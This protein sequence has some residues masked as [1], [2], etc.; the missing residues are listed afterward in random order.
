VFEQDLFT[1]IQVI[2]VG[3]VMLDQYWHGDTSRISPEA[4]VPVLKVESKEYRAGG[5]ANV[6]L[7]AAKLG[8][9][10]SIL[11]VVG[12]DVAARKLKDLLVVD[13]VLCN[14]IVA[15]EYPTTTKL[16]VVARNQQLIRCDTES[17]PCDVENE[18]IKAFKIIVQNADVVILSD[19]AKGVLS[20][21]QSFINICRGLNKPVIVDPK[22]KDFSI[23]AGATLLTPNLLEFDQAT[24]KVL[25]DINLEESSKKCIINNNLNALL[26]TR[27][28]KGMMLM[29]KDNFHPH[30]IS[31]N[32][33]E[34]F[35]ITGAGD[36]VIAVL[37]VMIAKGFSLEQSTFY[38]NLAAGIS[39]SKLGT[40]QVSI[41][42][43]NV[44]LSESIPM[45]ENGILSQEEAIKLVNV[46]KKIGKKIVFTNGCFDILH[47][48]HIDY[49]TKAK[50]L[51][52]IL[53]IGVNDDNS[54]RRLKGD[55][56]PINSLMNRMQ[57]LEAMQCVDYVVPF[58]EDTP[59]NLINSLIPDVLTKGGDYQISEIIGA[60]IV[61]KHGGKVH[62]L[63][64]IDGL[65]TTNTLRKLNQEVM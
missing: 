58:S 16:R 17:F 21:P 60:D 62:V 7:N 13:G 36:T 46:N 31:S 19:Y 26:V 37:G 12:N 51:G 48:G 14:F 52:D 56:R 42:E 32:A 1:N 53:V 57:L 55:T 39:V 28:A 34:V 40:A 63:P 3:D 33:R 5:A 18:L 11:S 6:A 50:E 49:L 35:D 41:Q 23:Y 9:K 25:N 45:A 64:F 44:V 29:E 20:S 30:Y 54:V 22:S 15:P 61:Q 47:A 8:A 10:T 2:V 43:L 38:A 27:G 24:G 59:F 65:S 4:P